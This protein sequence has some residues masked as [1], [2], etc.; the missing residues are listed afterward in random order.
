MIISEE[1]L[2]LSESKSLP[3]ELVTELFSGMKQGSSRERGMYDCLNFTLRIIC[4]HRTHLVT[5]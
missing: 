3:V 2:S 4:C 1:S 5:E